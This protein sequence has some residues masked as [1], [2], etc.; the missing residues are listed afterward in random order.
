MRMLVT[1]VEVKVV[2]ELRAETV[3]RKH[4]FDS[5]PYEFGRFLCENLLRGAETLSARISGMAH[6][7]LVGHLL[8]GEPYLVRV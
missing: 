2:D 6:V 8:A 7:H 3:L 5:H 4:A 1:C